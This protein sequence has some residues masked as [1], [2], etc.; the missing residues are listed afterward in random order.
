MVDC[1]KTGRGYSWQCTIIN[2][3]QNP[4]ELKDTKPHKESQYAYSN[5]TADILFNY[6]MY[7]VG[8]DFDSFISNFYKE[9]IKIEHPV[10]LWMNP[11]TAT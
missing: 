11:I 9:K 2:A 1:I 8:N 6:M 7:R 3:A 5:L 10:Y 4:K